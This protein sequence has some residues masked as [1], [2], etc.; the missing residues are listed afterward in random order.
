MDL[1]EYLNEIKITFDK[2]E[3][4]VIRFEMTEPSGDNTIII[5]KGRKVN[6][7]IPDEKFLVP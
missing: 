6:T 2:K 4:L 3:L 7:N 1:M 5:F